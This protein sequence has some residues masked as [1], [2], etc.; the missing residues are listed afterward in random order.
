MNIL[1]FDFF[2]CN[3]SSLGLV[4][5]SY[6]FGFNPVIFLY[7]KT[8]YGNFLGLIC[9]YLSNGL[10]F[11]LMLYFTIGILILYPLLIKI[12]LNAIISGYSSEH[13]LHLS[14]VN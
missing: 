13:V 12:L 4:S 7:L 5:N 10:E 1:F 11:R 6:N 2:F 8:N 14:D 9:F 3:V